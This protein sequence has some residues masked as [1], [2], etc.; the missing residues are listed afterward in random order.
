[1]TSV[2]GRGGGSKNWGGGGEK[3]LQ[4]IFTW[5]PHC[6]FLCPTLGD[7]MEWNIISYP[8]QVRAGVSA[9]GGARPGV[10]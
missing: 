6:G 8:E 1:M 5:S 10:W 9:E 2:A 4:I 3:K 7:G